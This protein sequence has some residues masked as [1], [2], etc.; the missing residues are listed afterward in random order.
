MLEYQHKLPKVRSQVLGVD[1]ISPVTMAQVMAGKFNALYDRVLI[2]DCRFDY[3]FAG[4][5][6]LVWWIY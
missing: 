2:V 4:A 5:S 1:A 3:E 6:Y